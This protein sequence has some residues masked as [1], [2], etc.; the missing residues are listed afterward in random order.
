[1]DEIEGS[2]AL[3][4]VKSSREFLLEVGDQSNYVFKQTIEASTQQ[5]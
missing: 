4:M 1:V 2:D 5:H 3:L